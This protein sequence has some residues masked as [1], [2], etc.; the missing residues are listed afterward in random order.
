[1]CY[2]SEPLL[3]TEGCLKVRILVGV[4]LLK[5][6]M[7]VGR[8]K[9]HHKGRGKKYLTEEEIRISQEKKDKEKE[10]KVAVAG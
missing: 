8:S 4:M 7:C 9:V 6:F 1:M 5:Y 10:W 2:S 3:S